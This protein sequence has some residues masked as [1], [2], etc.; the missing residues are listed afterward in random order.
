MFQ[1][2]YIRTW[3]SGNL[4]KIAEQFSD[5]YYNC[6]LC[7]RNCRVNR[8]KNETGVCEAGIRVKVSSAHAH[9]G[10]EQPLVGRNGSGTIFFSHCSML[11]SYCQNWD[12]SH[13][14]EGS[15][16]SDQ[17]LAGL[18]L[19]LQKQGCHNINVVTPT[20]FLPNI[21][22]GLLMA[23]EKG[24]QVP[25]VYNSSGYERLEILKMLDGIVDIYLPDCKYSD[26][27]L[28]A[29]YSRGAADYPEKVRIALKEMF[30]QV[31]LLQSNKYNIAQRGL[32]IRHLVLPH[33]LS[34]TRALVKFIVNELDPDIYV[35]I[36]AQYRP[37]YQAHQFPELSRG[38]TTL[39]Y[40][41][42][43]S[44]AQEYGLTNL[45]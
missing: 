22:R 19:K 43:L 12:I 14:G 24:L 10:E 29:I 27:K 39:E 25:L 21:I 45:D 3:K 20:H 9:F 5:I 7:P 13:N 28:A 17:D 23:V 2:V 40:T 1:P 18:M 31:G 38:I 11:C 8:H 37:H 42:A 34:G 26:S 6:T 32:M 41:Q 16:I 35:N 36:M 4:A 15:L 33:E 30:R 44:W